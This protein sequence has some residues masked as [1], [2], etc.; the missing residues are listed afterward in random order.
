MTLQVLAKVLGTPARS[1][2]LNHMQKTGEDRDCLTQRE[3]EWLPRGASGCPDP[4]QVWPLVPGAPTDG[5]HSCLMLV[6]NN[7]LPGRRF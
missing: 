3:W 1:Q 2:I 6:K 7:S 5:A 4:V